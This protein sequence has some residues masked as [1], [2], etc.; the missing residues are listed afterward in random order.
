MRREGLKNTVFTSGRL[1]IFREIIQPVIPS[2][3]N[4]KRRNNSTAYSYDTNNTRLKAVFQKNGK[5]NKKTVLEVSFREITGLTEV[6][7][8]FQWVFGRKNFTRSY[9]RKRY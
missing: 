5:L 1:V 4:D 8:F 6:L 3:N 7:I 9:R 2:E